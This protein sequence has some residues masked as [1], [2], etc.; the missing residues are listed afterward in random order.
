MTNLEVVLIYF[1]I[2][3]IFTLIVSKVRRCLPDTGVVLFGATCWIVIIIAML[4]SK[5]YKMIKKW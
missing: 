2:G 4:G 3:L 1:I 5:V